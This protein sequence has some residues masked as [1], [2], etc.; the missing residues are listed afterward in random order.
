M[1]INV[2]AES[3]VIRPTC[4]KGCQNENRLFALF[5]FK[6]FIHHFGHAHCV[7]LKKFLSILKTMK[8]ALV[9]GESTFDLAIYLYLFCSFLN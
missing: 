7:L 3:S 6:A 5:N 2:A 8:K 1:L 4:F 9:G